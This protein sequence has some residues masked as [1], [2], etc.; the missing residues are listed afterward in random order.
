MDSGSP[1][2]EE[3]CL[4]RTRGKPVPFAEGTGVGSGVSSVLSLA[5]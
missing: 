4:A 2:C 1:L 5:R 3:G